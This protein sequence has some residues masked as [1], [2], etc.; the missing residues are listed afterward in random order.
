MK[1]LFF[2]GCRILCCL[3]PTSLLF[4]QSPDTSQIDWSRYDYIPGH[5]ILFY[6]DF[7]ADRE[8]QAPIAWTASQ[9]G[10]VTV[11]K[12]N[13][14][15]WM[16]AREEATLSP[17]KLRLMPQFTLEMDFYVLTE[18]YSGRYRVDL[19]G[20]NAE[21]W[22]SLTLEPQSVFFSISTGLTSEKPVDLTTGV[23]HLAMQVDGSG[24]KCYIDFQQV[25]NIPKGGTFVATK[26]EI[27]MPGAGDEGN[28][29]QC[30]L[31]SLCVAQGPATLQNQL[32]ASGKIVS[33]GI[34]FE[35]GAANLLPASTPALKQLAELLQTDATLSFS[36]ECHDNELEDQGDNA[37]LSEARAEAIKDVLVQEYRISSNRLSIKGWGEGKPL[38]ERDTVEGHKMNRRVE[39]IRK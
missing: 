18:G 28:D 29:N 23:H 11:T 19:I 9:S 30:R 13:N 34:S 38:A 6:D 37:R 35:P 25:I 21:E 26:I 39:F 12:F 32:T 24:F 20:K 14:Q 31:T 27:F 3:S 33:Y 5:Q 36:I 4:A 7:T 17:A 1:K 8:G 2:V 22:A 16:H 10:R 15:L